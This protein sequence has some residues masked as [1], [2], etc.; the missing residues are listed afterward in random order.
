MSSIGAR[1]SRADDANPFKA[2]LA[3][4]RD[5]YCPKIEPVQ[6]RL[7]R[8]APQVYQAGNETQ[9]IGGAEVKVCSAAKTGADC[10]YYKNTVG[11]V[12]AP[13]ALRNEWRTRKTTMDELYNFA[14][15]CNIKNVI[16]PYLNSTG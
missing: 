12:V 2:W 9:L 16:L 8:F 15:V 10:F 4:T 13:E 11:L 1:F 6:T 3:S 7:F 5:A 14:V